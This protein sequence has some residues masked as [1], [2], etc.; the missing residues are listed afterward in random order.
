MGGPEGGQGD[1]LPG[2]RRGGS[3]LSRKIHKSA[4]IY[5]MLAKSENAA[6]DTEC[7][8]ESPKSAV[9]GLGSTP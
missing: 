3:T 8:K 4:L 2:D 6:P 9:K 7:G 1:K 5:S